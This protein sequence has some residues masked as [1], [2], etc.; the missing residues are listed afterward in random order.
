MND[1]IL[2]V[3][4]GES[5]ETNNS[6]NELK[7]EENK[8]VVEEVRLLALCPEIS[9]MDIFKDVEEIFENTKFI[10]KTY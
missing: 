6:N 10:E 4:D 5:I 2:A 8:F 3:W 1:E 7:F 9:E